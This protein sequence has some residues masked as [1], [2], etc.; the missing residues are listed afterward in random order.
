MGTSGP[1]EGFSTARL[2]PDYSALPERGER[3][4]LAPL[5]SLN[6][7]AVRV[8]FSDTPIESS[9]AY[10]GRL[11]FFMNQYWN[12]AT[13]GTLT[14][15]PTL[16]DSV[17]TLPHPMSYY[18]EDDRLQERL[19]F[20]V[21][22]LV[23]QADPQINFS[24]YQSLVIF[25]A[26]QGQEADVRDDSRGQIWSAFV[27]P[28]DFKT[29]LGDSAGV[30]GVATNDL[31]SPGVFYRVKETVELPE[32]ESQDGYVFGMTG[33]TCHEFGHQLGL[34]DLYDTTP[35]ENGNGQ[36]LGAWD[37]MATGVWNGNGFVPSMPSAWSRVFLGLG[38]NAAEAPTRIT[39]DAAVSL[40]HAERPVG[41]PPRLI[42]IPITQSE[43]FLIEN[44]DQDLNG[45]GKFNFDDAN[46]DGLFDFYTDSYAG[47][48]FDY[49]IPGSG[50]LIYHV[51]ESKI[52]AGLA[53]NVVNGDVARKGID[54]EEADGIQDLDDP[55]TALNA[56]SPDDTYREGWRTRFAP[57]T[58]P[59]S[60]AYGRIPTGI[61]ISNIGVLDSVMTF[62]V[63]FDRNRPGWPITLTGS[64]RNTPP[65]AADL[66]G[67]G[68]LELIVP[69]A[70]LNNTGAIYV[71][72]PDAKDF[73]DRDGNPAT[74]DAFAVTSSRVITTPCVGDVDGDGKADLVFRTQN[75][76]IYAFHAD[77]TEVVDGDNDPTTLG[78]V[79]A[80]GAPSFL[81]RAQIILADLD[82]DGAQ[83]IVSG[84]RANAFGGSTVS[85]ITLA[86]GGLTIH[87]VALGGSTEA[88]LVA[89]DLDGDGRPE[90]IASN[91]VTLAA[92]NAVN[93]LSV[94]PWEV[95]SD[96]NNFLPFDSYLVWL[97]GPFSAPVAADLN[98]DGRFDVVVADSSGSI[99]ALTFTLRPHTP[100]SA[101]NS[102]IDVAE[103]PGW[104]NP[105]PPP[106]GP[107]SE[108]SL[109]DLE[110][111]GYP[112]VFQ[113]GAD[114]R[115]VAYYY[116]GAPRSGFPVRAGDPL[117][118]ADTTG[119]WAPLVADVDG[120][121]FRDVVPILPD[122]RRIG[123]RRDGRAIASFG[124]LGSTAAGP[125]PILA[126]L[127]G[128]GTAEWV[129][130]YDQG[131]QIQ[132]AVRN[133]AIAA[134]GA[135]AAW[136][137][138]R[139]GP[140][141]DGVLPTGPVGPASGTRVLSEVYGY[142]NPSRADA[143][144][145][146]YRLSSPARSVR[147]RIVDAT[148][149]TVAEPAVGPASLAGSAEH[150]VLWNHASLASGVYICR[151]EVQ[152]DRGTE[153]G[154]ANLAVLR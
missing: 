49:F 24:A 44:R 132:I 47:A 85:S 142:P 123:L 69:V 136:S 130:A 45:D 120:D 52:A 74:R 72:E 28:E 134:T 91:V 103:L 58:N 104:P 99:H 149:A 63:A 95:L 70:R 141:R 100:G 8:A 16:W 82:G 6:V 20:L 62:D 113:T 114:S 97:G 121:G 23:A 119:T 145:I 150:A 78:V 148:G 21:R 76:A 107:P 81:T 40:A 10:Y 154:F 133:T 128:N 96:P 126:D 46:A 31:V 13:D 39:R 137:Q 151:V 54:L 18:G 109:G 106:H 30:V 19:V 118:P 93:G 88:P 55:P 27:T 61:T 92:E 3:L 64:I 66:N 77:G 53:A 12:Q 75:G 7:L 37:I 117:A 87:T 56:G 50:V 146:H 83:E 29:V 124:E 25:H 43:Y 131:T 4:A 36:G 112:E 125:P 32:S 71:L 144:T 89:A 105:G 94:I 108:P 152:S 90:L 57:D 60:E 102:Y 42:E 65:V 135:W 111:D 34:P 140:S 51:D 35:D 147:I 80:G 110:G 11:L 26:G 101:P 139:N 15:T 73:F 67:D 98:R 79:R 2:R 33:V 84:S 5:T 38:G 86:G 41:A 129:E 116:N 127:D 143:T 48:E 68:T 115:V 122:G 14:L 9:T 59:S 22:D 17:Y 138:Y 1:K 153:V